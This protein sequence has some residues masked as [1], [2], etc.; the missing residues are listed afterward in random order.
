MVYFLTE[1]GN[2]QL[3]NK[4]FPLSKG[5]RKHLE[6]TL[7]ISRTPATIS[8]LRVGSVLT[9]FSIWRTA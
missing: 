2:S 5:I 4:M 6:D 3:K 8:M 7:R 9:I 1:D